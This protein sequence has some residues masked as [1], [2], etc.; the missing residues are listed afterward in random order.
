MTS[1]AAASW[2]LLLAVYTLVLVA[3]FLLPVPKAQA[4]SMDDCLMCHE[5]TDLTTE[6][7]G[8]EIS[9]FVDLERFEGSVHG[10]LECITCHLDLD[11]TDFPHEE[12]LESVDCSM[13]HDDVAETYSGSVHGRARSGG[14][15]RAPKCGNCHSAHEIVPIGDEPSS[16]NCERCHGSIARTYANSIHGRLVAEGAELAPQCWDCHG[17]HDIIA[18]N[19]PNSRV[20]KFNIPFMCGS[21]HKEGTEVTRSYNIPQDSIVSHYSQS[22]HGEGLYQRGLTVTAVCTNCHTAHN[23]LPHTN[24]E[25]SIHRDN[26]AG[27]CQQCH[28]RIEQVHLQVIR[29]ELWEREPHK[30]PACVDC[31]S[32]HKARKVFYELGMADRDCLVCHERP[33]I[34]TVRDGETVSLH[35]DTTALHDSDHRSVACAQCH[36]GASVSAERSCATITTRVDCSVC[37]AK[38]AEDYAISVHGTLADRGDLNAP[39]CLECHGTHDIRNHLDSKSPTYATAI[40]ELCGKCHRAGEEV[41]ARE[42]IHQQNVVANYTMS[43]HGKGL[44]ES[45][46]VVTARCT[47]CHTAHRELPASDPRSSV[48]PDN[49]PQTCARCHAGIYEQFEKSIHSPEVSDT[50]K[51]L[52][53][54]ADCH[55]SHTITRT[56]QEGFKLEIIGQCGRCHEDVMATYFD[57][58]HGK[59]SR[60]GYTGA[61]KC[62]DCHGSHDVLPNYMPDSRLSRDHVVETC[63]QCHE[64][65]HRRFAGYLTHATHHDRVKYP[66][67]F[68]TFWFMTTLLV[69]T[70]VLASIHTILWLPRSFKT[71]KKHAKERK[72][73]HGREFRRF[74]PLPRRLHIMVIV[75]FIGLAVTGM[76]LK[77]SYLSWAQWLSHVLGG[78][79][80]TGYIHR[81]CAVITFAYFF[82]HI[83]DV[84]RQKRESGRS[85]FKFLTGPN[86]MLP[87]WKDWE[88]LKGTF[89]WFIG[90]GP[91]PAYGR[92]TYWEKFDYF[93]VFWGVAIIGSTGLI[94]WFPE[95]FTHFLPGW[96][97]N[98][99]TI[100]HSD[101][102]LLA[103]GF[104]F[105]VH[106]FNTHFRPDKF[107][108]DMVMFT[109]RIPLEEFK[110]DRPEEYDE[111]VKSGKLE[112]HLVDPLPPYVVNGLKVFGAT[113]LVIGVLLIWLIIYAEIFGYR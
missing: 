70:L 6:R 16:I 22:I 91:R 64:G 104:I 61:A 48:Y 28:G 24:A 36:T 112:E 72:E 42:T 52:P 21:C 45:G 106:F 53:I 76:T 25:S 40:P 43:I 2:S 32:P 35:V 51:E 13:C 86:S 108:M 89:K 63:G 14:N 31:H 50:D 26:V 77:F 62:Y 68:Y 84:F 33:D 107:P 38:Q 79:E 8:R 78:F 10:D 82:I 1:R 47:D 59:V 87:R 54:C 100:I 58:F 93:A 69:S 71:M 37:H 17:S 27:T 65:A 60:L 102:A 98:V 73:P 109:G 94:L 19:E 80:S 75:S 97:I 15:G 34:S 7:E 23:V 95:F 41:A 88:D 67:L 29:G 55:S 66:V 74:K 113:A 111:L 110:V 105:T 20:E 12:R 5:D 11:G 96:F 3:V 39:T 85:W 101:E 49:I 83:W 56:D 92:W 4:Q 9:L 90:M 44:L 46:L 103:V 18:H 30:V 57:T 99:A 81:V